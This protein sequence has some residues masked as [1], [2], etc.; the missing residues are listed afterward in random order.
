MNA[1]LGVADHYGSS[2]FVTIAVADKSFRLASRERVQLID[3]RLPPAPYHHEAL[4][5][6]LDAAE[7]LIAQVRASVAERCR[8]ALSEQIAKFGIGAVVIQSSPYPALPDELSEIL[9]SWQITCAADG[10]MYREILA[11][12]ANALGLEVERYPRKSDR[13]AAAAEA[14]RTSNA[15]VAELLQSFGKQAGSPWR[16]EHQE[17]A[18]SA[19]AYLGVA[20]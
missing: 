13:V 10:M 18:A 5:M 4:E 17:A 6:P 8:A 16:K 15:R 12:S 1:A 19:L 7:K 14:L 20:I 3:P 11:S 2:E 9:A